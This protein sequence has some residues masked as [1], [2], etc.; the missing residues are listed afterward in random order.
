MLGAILL[1]AGS[2]CVFTCLARIVA[3]RLGLIDLPDGQRKAHSHPTPLMGGV[4]LFFSLSITLG[5][6]GVLKA[7]S[8]PADPDSIRL[9]CLI[10]VS[11]GLFCLLGF[12]DD[13][14]SLRPR[15]KLLFQIAASVP[16]A[17]WGRSIETVELFGGGF[18]LGQFGILFTIFWLVAC[19]NVINLVDGLDGLAGTIG[20]IVCVAI[21]AHSAI[22]EMYVAMLLALIFAASLFGFLVHNWPPAKIFLG[23]SGS[24]LIGFMIGALSI[25]SS[26][27]KATSFAMVVP[28]ILVSVPIFDT[29]MAILRRKLNGRGI[30]EADRGHIHHCLQD[31][32][33]TR[34]KTLLALSGLC[35][36]MVAVSMVAAY[37]GS[38]FLALGMCA[39]LLGLLIV[40]RIFGYNET[41]LFFH[42]MRVM[43]LLLVDA[44]GI[45]RTRL[46][47][48]R[49]SRDESN[50]GG[51]FWDDLTAYVQMMGGRHLEF[52][53]RSESSDT[54]IATRVWFTDAP[55]PTLEGV[56]LADWQ[57]SYSLPG[58]QRT[59]ATLVASGASHEQLRGERMID[60]HQLFASYCRARVND[61]TESISIATQSVPT[62]ALHS[63]QPRTQPAATEAPLDSHRTQRKVA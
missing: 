2:S 61:E 63:R 44:S 43:S 50:V 26:L 1:A 22:N 38:D 27:K 9:V 59:R 20:M 3:P 47:L 36:A 13:C 41:L 54:V 49:M 10:L 15:T 25:E 16:F 6:V 39:S 7:G 55:E 19:T 30:G 32:G 11:G 23:D 35:V 51:D 24:L 40:G 48:A 21:A 14:R 57:F 34:S 46:F 56:P 60:L 58:S 52:V 33:Y 53:H 5:L 4:A 18:E 17:V 42:Y 8:I 45:F 28:L 29:L 62:L 12:Y 31:R 37:F